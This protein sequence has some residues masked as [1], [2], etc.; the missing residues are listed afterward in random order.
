M[1]LTPCK[2]F[3]GSWLEILVSPGTF[4]CTFLLLSYLVEAISVACICPIQCLLSCRSSIDNSCMGQIP[5]LHIYFVKLTPLVD[6]NGQLH[7]I[8]V[9]VDQVVL[10]G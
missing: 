3:L 10:V 7:T 5:C 6:K 4:L 1:F 2:E 9:K 8:K